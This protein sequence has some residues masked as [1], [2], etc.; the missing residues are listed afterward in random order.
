[1]TRRTRRQRAVNALARPR[2]GRRSTW[3]AALPALAAILWPVV[4][5]A[6]TNRVILRVND[7][8]ATLYDYEQMK[9]D[10]L[11]A[12]AR[13]DLPEERKQQ[14]AARLGEDTMRQLF[15][16]MLLLSRAEQLGVRISPDQLEAAMRSTMAGFGIDSVEEFAAGLVQSGTSL[17]RWREQMRRSLLVREVMGREIQERVTLEEEDL[18]RYYRANSEEFRRPRRVELREIVVLDEAGMSAAEQRAL[19]DEL[20][21]MIRSGDAGLDDELARLKDSGR[22]T[23]WIDLGWVLAGDLDP[24]L[25]PVVAGLDAGDVSAPTVAR[26][27]LHVLQA[28]DVEESRIE[29]FQD[30]RERIDRQERERLFEEE[31]QAYLEELVASSYIVSRP[32]PEAAGFQPLQSL[33]APAQGMD[34]G[35]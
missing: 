19:A 13:S 15:E 33:A 26:G 1:M 25:E 9:S 30:V 12:L 29:E 3:L 10:Q 23:G 35:G 22:S 2:A 5:D 4:A 17:E 24:R 28:L 11:A 34:D 20:A 7:E 18:R 6:Q 14:I 27:G 16:E 21:A 8:I 32:P 31:A